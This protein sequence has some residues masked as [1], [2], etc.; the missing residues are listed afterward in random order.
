MLFYT[1]KSCGIRIESLA[2]VKKSKFAGYIT[3]EVLTY[4]STDEKLVNFKMLTQHEANWLKNY[5]KKCNE[6]FNRT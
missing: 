5:N 4:V 3:F 2:Y 1:P 6:I